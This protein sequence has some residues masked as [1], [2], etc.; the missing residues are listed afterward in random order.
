MAARVARR[1]GRPGRGRR[2]RVRMIGHRHR[3]E[4]DDVRDID[5]DAAS[6]DELLELADRQLRRWTTAARELIPPDVVCID[7]HCHLGADS[8]GST[9]SV[10][11]LTAQLDRAGMQHAVVLALHQHGGY[12]LENERIRGVAHDSNGRFRALH[13]CDPRATDPAMDAR[14]ALEEGAAGLKWHPRAE[15]FGMDADVAAATALVAE[16]YGV[17]VLVHAGRGMERLGE[18]VVE[19]ARAHPRATFVLAHAA[20]SDLAWIVDASR[21]V[22]NLMFDTS[23]WRPTDIATLL[24]S[25]DPLRV[26]HGS[27]PPYGTARLGLQITARIARACGWSDEAMAA[28]MGA[29]AARVFG[30]GASVAP[31]A[32]RDHTPHQPFETP[33]FRRAM[34][35]IGSA[36]HVE[37]AG[38]NSTEVF[39]LGCAALDLAESHPDADAAQSLLSAILIG[40]S[41]IARGT[42]RDDLDSP[43]ATPS[44]SPIRRLGIELIIAALAHLATPALPVHGIDRVGWSDPA[45]FV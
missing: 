39:E 2:G 22:P 18:G 41:L 36:V 21:D 42:P 19:L 29:N 35:L 3:T 38:G 45:P 25:V 27:D 1:S 13:R 37:L 14:R 4:G 23:W 12:A 5:V 7:A 26:L 43:E 17:P 30:F 34:E 16:E 6:T 9:M 8:D 15:R 44:P 24:V 28:L 20:V 40:E 32:I 31:V 33:A 10:D 11:E